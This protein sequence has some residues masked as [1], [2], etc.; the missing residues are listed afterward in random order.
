MSPKRSISYCADHYIQSIGILAKLLV[1]IENNTF[2]AHLVSPVC[3]SY[4]LLLSTSVSQARGSPLYKNF[5]C[6]AGYAPDI[7]DSL[8]RNVIAA[9]HSDK[10]LLSV[11][12]ELFRND[13]IKNLLGTTQAIDLVRGG[14]KVNALPER[15]YAVVNHRISVER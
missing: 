7:L 15:A 10:A 13:E 6:L 2:S 8:G 12:K 11:E 5:Q 14:V 4:C 3:M 9:E 1:A